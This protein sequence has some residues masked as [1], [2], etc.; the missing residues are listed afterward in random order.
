L[1]LHFKAFI[2]I[3]RPVNCFMMGFA[4]ILSMCLAFNG[5]P[6]LNLI[7]Y[8]FL[9][10]FLLTASSMVINDLYD[11]KVDLIN[12][13]HRPLPKGLI[14]RSGAA[15]YGFLLSLLGLFSSLQINFTCFLIA[16]ISF[17]VSFL[18]NAK[19]KV[20]GLMGN[21]MVSFCVAV[22]FIFGGFSVNSPSSLLLYIFSFAAFLANTGREVTKGIIDVEGDIVRNVMSVARKYGLDSA[23]RLASIFYI[24]AV[25]VGVVPIFLGLVSPLYFPFI[26]LSAFG[27][28]YDSILLVKS[29]TPNTA[30]NVKKRILIYMF[31]VMLGVF[32]GGY[33]G[34]KF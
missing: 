4:V 14:S 30:L 10:G 31:I 25:A 16:L 18:Y 23:G 22:P 13:P 29:P 15:V 20:Y 27:F 12:A 7:V 5:F 2:S 24:A 26:L 8:G 6:P 9:S 21:F 3:I 28:I 19:F 34:W 1:N 33:H 32:I 11:V 17:A